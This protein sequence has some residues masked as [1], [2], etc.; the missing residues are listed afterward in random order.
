MILLIPPFPCS[1][2]DPIEEVQHVSVPPAKIPMS[3][4]LLCPVLPIVHSIKTVLSWE[5]NKSCPTF[6]LLGASTETLRELWKSFRGLQVIQLPITSV[7]PTEDFS[8]LLSPRPPLSP[9]SISTH[10]ENLPTTLSS[11]SSSLSSSS[12]ISFFFPHPSSPCTPSA[13]AHSPVSGV[14]AGKQWTVSRSGWGRAKPSQGFPTHRSLLSFSLPSAFF[15]S[16]KL[17][18]C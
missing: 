9:S 3:G 13:L 16:L 4:D 8:L 2:F 10:C 15:S 11:F 6:L 14:L 5:C 18:I 12:V 1:N 7:L 17:V